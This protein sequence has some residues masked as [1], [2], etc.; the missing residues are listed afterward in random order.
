M[1]STFAQDVKQGLSSTPKR[2][3]SK[4]FYD[5]KGSALFSQIMK[6]PE[7]YLT[8]A[9]FEIFSEQAA[10]ICSL[11]DIHPN[12]HFDLIEL[13]AGDG[14]KTIELLKFL[15]EENYDYRYHPVDISKKALRQIETNISKALPEMQIHPV[16]GDY[17]H[18]LKDLGSQ[19]KKRVVMFLGSNI[20]NMNDSQAQG[21][22]EA[23][24]NSLNSGDKIILGVDLKKSKDIV[25]PAYNDSQNI[26]KEFNLNLLERI[27]RELDANFNI[28]QFD[29]APEYDEKEGI[30]RSAIVSL[31]DQEVYI[32]AVSQGFSFKAGEKIHTE[33]SRKYDD[34]LIQELC[35]VAGLNILGKLQDKKNL[36]ADYVLIK[37]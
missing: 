29:H 23:L 26:T 16:K 37:S 35:K 32:A 7:Y 4:Y 28:E 34:E 36:F 17:F 20:G 6:L 14:Y 21:F 31:A 9:E 30:A 3:S 19:H 8:D 13:G 12:T 22:L 2:L 11:L 10:D 24:A 5:E 33:I 18:V 15:E 25:L 1:I 27:N